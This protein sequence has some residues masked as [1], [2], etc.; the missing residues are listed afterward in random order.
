[1]Q[2]GCDAV[3]DHARL[4]AEVWWWRASREPRGEQQAD[5]IWTTEVQVVADDGFEELA[6]VHGCGEDLGLAHLELPNAQA[7]A[8]AGSTIGRCEWP[9]QPV[10]PAI[11]ERLYIGWAE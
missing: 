10:E 4:V 1:M 3:G 7:V 6:P 2:A 5:A 8:I 11:E 9:G